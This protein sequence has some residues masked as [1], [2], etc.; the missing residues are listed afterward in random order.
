MTA[1]TRNAVS[2][3]EPSVCI[4][5]VSPGTLRKRKYLTAAD[6]AGPLL[7]P[8]EREV[9]RLLHPLLAHVGAWGCL[10]SPSV[11]R[12]VEGIEPLL[13]AVDVLARADELVLVDLRL[14][15]AA[16]DVR[17][18][19]RAQQ[20]EPAVLDLEVV[21]V[22]R[23]HRR[24]GG[25]VALR[26]VLAAVARAAEAGRN[27]RAQRDRA[28]LR[29]LGLVLHAE[30][31]AARAVRL[32][33]AAEMRA[34]VGDDREARHLLPPT[35][36]LPL[37]RTNAVR[38]E[39]SPSLGSS[40]N[41]AMYHW[42]SVKSATGPRST[43]CRFWPRNPG[44]T[45]KPATGTVTMPPMTPPSPRVAP[46]RN[47]LRGKRSPSLVNGDAGGPAARPAPP[48]RGP[49]WP[50]SSAVASRAQRTPKTMAIAPPMVEIQSGLMIRPTRRTAMPMAKPSGQRVGGGRWARRAVL[51]AHLLGIQSAPSRASTS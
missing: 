14:R 5:F 23:A 40:M 17:D 25:A 8:V 32:H 28:V 9:D 48:R 33:R 11:V 2:V 20:H 45:A 12:R 50:R 1:C 42:P 7:E 4:Q 3:A 36:R 6:E 38:R 51:L 31:R 22:E 46:S 29:L 21:A 30:D 15:A 16:V 44:R 49:A 10:R 24:A 43:S 37:L 35:L 34:P 27:G 39:T 19:V 26:V 47:L 41:V 13:G 18:G